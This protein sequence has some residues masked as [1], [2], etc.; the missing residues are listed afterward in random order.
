MALLS[1]FYF[2]VDSFTCWMPEEVSRSRR[3]ARCLFRTQ[4]LIGNRMRR[5][6]SSGLLRLYLIL[7]YI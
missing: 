1:C 2:T 3:V 7:S 6:T 4:H 5:D